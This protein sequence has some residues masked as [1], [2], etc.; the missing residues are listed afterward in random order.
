V[1]IGI[2]TF[3]QLEKDWQRLKRID[4][5]EQSRKCGDKQRQYLAHEHRRIFTTANPELIVPMLLLARLP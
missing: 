3:K 4:D 1:L 5:R 2:L